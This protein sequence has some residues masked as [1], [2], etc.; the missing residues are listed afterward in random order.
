VL[1]YVTA[2]RFDRRM[3]LGKTWPCLLA[4]DRDDGEEV[5]L[6]GKFSAG[7]E[8]REG[9][10]VIEAIAAL[11]AA[12]LDLPVPEPFLVRMDEGFIASLPASE[13][14]LAERIRQSSRVAFGSCLLPTGFSVWAAERSVAPALRQQAA[15]IF[16]FDCLLAN[17]DRRPDNP[18]L[19]FDG[20]SFAIFDHELALMQEGIL[21]WKPP[22][23]AGALGSAASSHVLFT[24]LSGRGYDWA[25]LEGAWEAVSDR[26]LAEYRA[27]LPPEWSAGFHAADS[28]LAYLG[29][30]RDNIRPA[31]AEVTRVLA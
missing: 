16:A 5:E 2:Q 10:L 8:R 31:L 13:H 24:G 11:L 6:V 12:D 26:R 30:L 7:C 15:E 18:N 17:P 9:G 23:Q 19:K 28:A 14:A 27:A 20:K 3:S 25:R 1:D 22:W 21:W 29:Q 4:C